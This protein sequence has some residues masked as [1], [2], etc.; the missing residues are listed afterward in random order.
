MAKSYKVTVI[1][2]TKVIADMALQVKNATIEASLQ[3]KTVKGGATSATATI[4]P[5]G[6]AGANRKMEDVEGWFVNGTDTNPP[7]A[8]GT[9]WEAKTGFKNTNWWDGTANTWSLGSDVPLPTQDISGKADTVNDEGQVVRAPEVTED[10]YIPIAGTDYGNGSGYYSK[11]TGTV[12][13]SAGRKRILFPI[14][15]TSKD[16]VIS[17]DIGGATLIALAVYFTENM[18]RIGH[19]EDVESGEETFTR[20]ALNPP[21]NARFIGSGT[22]NTRPQIKL[23]EHVTSGQYKEAVFKGDEYLKTEIANETV[24]KADTITDEGHVVRAPEVSSV[25]YQNVVGT[26]YGNDSG[27]YRYDTGAVVASAGRKRILFPIADNKKFAITSTM[28]G[29]ANLSLGVFFD[30]NM[31]YL[32]YYQRVQSGTLSVVRQDVTGIPANAKF[33]GAANGNSQGAIVLEEILDIPVYKGVAFKED[34]YT[35]EQVDEKIVTGL[36]GAKTLVAGTSI[37]RNN[38]IGNYGTAEMLRDK[39]NQTLYMYAV[40]GATVAVKTTDRNDI[41]FQIDK[42]VADGVN[43]DY[44]IFDGITNDILNRAIP[45]LIGD[46]STGYDATFDTS[47][48]TGALEY[49]CKTIQTTWPKAK[50]TFVLPYKMPTRPADKQ[51]LWGQRVLDVMKKWSIPVLDQA[52]EGIVNTYIPIHRDTFCPVG[53]G[54]THLNLLGVQIFTY[55]QLESKL[56]TL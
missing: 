18:T 51:E 12:Q 44:I 17:G 11:T 10:T 35:K 37:M 49:I 50:K 38:E 42:A 23:E 14:D 24:S 45:I 21:S 33:F 29:A 3:I 27:Y 39:Y 16:Y 7:V 53:D 43:P 30:E 9:P 4:L 54:G 8:T 26:S 15:P 36:Q 56:K 46:I 19:E 47:T 41:V 20:F 31:A 52:K 48:F 32:G 40:G 55:P 6:P 13:A 22:Y 1:A 2:G 28:T 25:S 34:V 5:P